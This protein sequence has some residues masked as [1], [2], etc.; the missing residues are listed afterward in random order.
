[1]AT[2]TIKLTDKEILEQKKFAQKYLDL[3]NKELSYADLLDEDNVAAYAKSYKY[4]SSLVTSGVVQIESNI[5]HPRAIVI[6][7]EEIVKGGGINQ[8]EEEN[9]IS[10]ASI[11]YEF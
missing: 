7:K 11:V 4:H 3:L 9:T 1:M 8:T 2:Q 10:G 5:A 6:V